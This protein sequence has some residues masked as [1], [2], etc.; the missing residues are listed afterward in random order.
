[1][2]TTIPGYRIQ[3]FDSAS[4]SFVTV[5]DGVASRERAIE[6]ASVPHNESRRVINEKGTVVWS[7][8][9]EGGDE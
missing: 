6:M 9:D 3:G 1:M 7:S 2:E 8:D 4:E 5:M